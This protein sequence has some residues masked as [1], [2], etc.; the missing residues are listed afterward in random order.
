[1]KGNEENKI[2]ESRRASQRLLVGAAKTVIFN[3]E[4]ISFEKRREKY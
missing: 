1:M 3:Y 2:K 4:S